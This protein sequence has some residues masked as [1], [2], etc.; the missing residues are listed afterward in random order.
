ML[1]R[2]EV[3]NEEGRVPE[4]KSTRKKVNNAVSVFSTNAEPEEDSNEQDED[5]M[6]GREVLE[7]DDQEVDDGGW[8]SG[9][10]DSSAQESEDER[11][12]EGDDNQESD[13]GDD[14]VPP[15]KKM[16]TSSAHPPAKSTTTKP[17]TKT[18]GAAASTFLPSLSVGFTRGDSDSEPEDIDSAPKKNRRGQR[19]RRA[20]VIMTP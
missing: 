15:A 4:S 5:V 1:F 12:S 11:T 10:I 6:S 20:Y 2:S 9:S 16:K 18:P 14:E 13:S 8:E 19:A 7:E 17:E 3:E